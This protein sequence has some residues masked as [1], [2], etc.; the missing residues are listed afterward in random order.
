[1][2]E[3]NLNDQV[4]GQKI[5]T[6]RRRVLRTLAP[7][8]PVDWEARGS[9][10]LPMNMRRLASSG[11]L[12]HYYLIYLLLVDLL[13]FENLGRWEKVAWSIPM[14]FNGC[15]FLMEHRKFGV[16]LF[17][18]DPPN[19]DDHAK[20]IVQRIWKAV[21]LAGPFFD[22]LAKGAIER[23]DVNVANESEGLLGRYEY[24]LTLFQDKAKEAERRKDECEVKR[25]SSSNGSMKVQSFTFPAWTLRK[26][27]DWLA[28]SAIESFFSWTE[29][30]FIHVALLRERVTTAQQVADLAA[31]D[32][33]VKFTA[34]IDL[35]EKGANAFL[36]KLLN[37]RKELRNHVAHGA[38]G[39]QG[40]AFRFHSGAGAVPVLLPHKASRNRFRLGSGLD[41]DSNAAIQTMQEFIEFLWSGSRAPAYVYIQERA[42][43]VVLPMLGSEGFRLAMSSKEAMESFVD[44]LAHWQDDAANMDW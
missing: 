20:E 27:R 42:L 33:K 8:K 31:S 6:V 28:I 17:S 34:A 1:M 41:F 38:F 4:D 23:S 14:D 7:I 13:G 32:W 16:G 15:T 12:P 30:V 43:P 9:R 3:V 25:E 2:A 11:E 39:K 37:I 22:T 44:Q 40:E 5:E 35:D 29:H 10:D 21:R 24:L 26:E 36:E 19:E 18:A